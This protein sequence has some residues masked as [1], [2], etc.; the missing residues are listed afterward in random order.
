[1]SEKR[2]QVSAGLKLAS[3]IQCDWPN[4]RMKFQA[5]F[6]LGDNVESGAGK[7][8]RMAA[9]R[10]ALFCNHRALASFEGEL[11]EYAGTSK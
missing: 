11:P 8:P 4:A 5:L 7:D 2:V 10:D 9:F 6:G 3:R 1:M